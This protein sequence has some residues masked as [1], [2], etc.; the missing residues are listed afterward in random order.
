MMK[1][2]KLL[3]LGCAL[4]C[5]GVSFSFSG[6]KPN[7]K[8]RGTAKTPRESYGLTIP[9][10]STVPKI[11]GVLDNPLWGKAAVIED[12]TQFEPLE[13]AVPSEKTKAYLAY[14]KNNLYLA[15][16]CFD[17]NPKAIRACLTQRDKAEQ[18]DEVTIYLDTF[19]DKKRAFVFQ[20]NPCGIQT[21]GIL[22][23]GTGRRRM[24][25]ERFDRNWDTYFLA[26]AH[27]DDQGY[28]V[29]MAIPF[30]SL[31]FPNADSQKWGLK[32]VR[33]IRRKNEEDHWPPHSRDVN[34]FLV[35]SGIIEFNGRIEKGKNIEI[36][37]VVT[38]LQQTGDKFRPEA[39]LNL[40]WG[41]TSD[42]VFD[43]TYNPDF[44]QV[45][46]DMPQIDVNQRYALYFPEKRPFFLEGRDYFDTPFE[47]IYTR[48]IVNPQWGVK[49]TGKT[50]G[51]TMG[52][53]SAMDVNSPEITILDPA[54]EDGGEDNGEPEILYRSLVNVLRLKKDLF[55]ESSIGIILTDKEEGASWQNLTSNYNRVAGVD[56]QFKFLNS[57][58]FNFQAVG[59]MTKWGPEKTGLVPAYTFSLSHNSRHLQLSADYS[60]I[61]PDFEASLGFFR[62]KDIRFFSTRAGYAFLPQN[63]LIVTIRP[64]VEY[65]RIYDFGG[66]LTDDE[67][68]VSCFLSGWRQTFLWTNFSSGLERYNG[69]NF[70]QKDFMIGLGSEPLSWL[71]GEIRYFFGD[72]IYYDLDPYLGYETGLETSLM[73]KPLSN[74]ALAYSYANNTFYKEKGG[75]N[76]YKI[77]VI[78][79]RINY[80]I[81]RPLSLRLITDYNDYY[82]ELYA[83][84]LL[85]YEYRPGTV[86]YIGV[87]DNQARDEN[88]IFRG[89][90]RYYFIKFSY[91]WRV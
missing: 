56:G 12:F 66:N 59:S 72:G 16:R 38:G 60:S 64:S 23:E 24:G 21:D 34:G 18:D 87:D 3:V 22:T 79:Q 80:Q 55:S 76:V 78:S 65:R 45:E 49:L 39:G 1:A 35:Q 83:S 20:I 73:L 75:A 63:D 28:T 77:N 40:K 13:G 71:S 26:D 9:E 15:F 61:P 53:L 30:K 47:L 90:G 8:P 67:Y 33:S 86:F 50:K 37:P 89:T 11:D 7:K 52:V 41:V 84:V 48:T 88:G 27:M 43:S 57:N 74:L 58:R 68:S 81:T 2:I 19:N 62:R 44:S 85:S 51:F 29:E 70:Y 10:F 6:G 46:A 54:E 69:V 82:K 17:S 42:M 5:L 36:M 91:W 4:V 25:F 31:R 32:I 14:D